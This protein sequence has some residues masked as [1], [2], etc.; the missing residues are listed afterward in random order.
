[1]SLGTFVKFTKV[2][3]NYT[4]DDLMHGK[5]VSIGDA[6]KIP[7]KVGSKIVVS[8]IKKNQDIQE[9][10]IYYYV[11]ENQIMDILL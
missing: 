10:Q 7:I 8:T 9:G 4:S 6:V 3:S 1:M 2:E 5:V 11:Q